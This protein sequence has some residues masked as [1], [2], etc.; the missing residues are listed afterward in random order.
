MH[1]EDAR[2]DTQRHRVAR[3][4]RVALGLTAPEPVQDADLERLRRLLGEATG[5]HPVELSRAADRHGIGLYLGV[6]ADDPDAAR[7]AAVDGV[8]A[9]LGLDARAVRWI[10]DARGAVVRDADDPSCEVD[11]TW[12]EQDGPDADS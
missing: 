5:W 6:A 7:R 8:R 10:V 2:P 11:E 9:L 1:A 3:R 12:P 4:Y